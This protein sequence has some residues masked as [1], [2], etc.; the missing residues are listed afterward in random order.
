MTRLLP[1]TQDRVALLEMGIVALAAPFLLFPAFHRWLTVAACGALV[2]VWLT[3][4]CI[5]R[6]PGTPTVLDIPL[7][8]L[9]CT[10]PVAVWASA[11]PELTL[12]K[13]TSLILGFAAFRALVN[14]VRTSRQLLLAVALFLLLGLAIGIVG[15]VSTSWYSEWAVLRSVF[16]R[17]PRLISGMPGAATGTHPNQ[18]AGILLLFLPISVVT[19]WV[20]HHSL[21]QRRWALRL[22]AVLLVI[23][24]LAVLTITLSRSAWIGALAGGAVAVSIRWRP[25]RWVLLAAVLLLTYGV[26]VTGPREAL[27]SLFPASGSDGIESLSSTVTLV[28]RLELWNLALYSIQDFPFTGCGLGA[29]REVVRLFY[30]L[31]IRSPDFD[32]AHAHNMLLQVALDLGLPGLIAYL[33]LTGTTLWTGLR[34]ALAPHD[35]DGPFGSTYHWL[36]LGIVASLVAYHVYGLTDAVALGA[37]PGVAYWIVLALAAALWNVAQRETEVQSGS[38]SASVA[39]DS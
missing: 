35:R 11:F 13:L 4:W 3:R 32:I 5:C 6:Q 15:L 26:V 21:P 14:A 28:G 1:D 27:A 30:P 9:M 10:V 24:F 22:A 8:V 33:A 23:F 39:S 20:N 19:I 12:P 36:A 17:I 31:F 37:K 2:L 29:F 34:I 18:L 7:L 16:E 25:V 38:S